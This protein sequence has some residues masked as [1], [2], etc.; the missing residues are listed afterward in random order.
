[1]SHTEVYRLAKKNN[2][3]RRKT[4]QKANGSLVG[5]IFTS[6]ARNLKELHVESSRNGRKLEHCECMG[7]W[8]WVDD[9]TWSM[10]TH[11]QSHFNVMSCEVSRTRGIKLW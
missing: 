8:S 7:M 1:M 2:T 9:S 10:I 3:K 4:S 6:F 5:G 11:Q